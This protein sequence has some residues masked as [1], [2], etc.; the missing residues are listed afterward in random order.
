MCDRLTAGR[1]FA[2]FPRSLEFRGAEG[3][4][5]EEFFFADRLR[6]VDDHLVKISRGPFIHSWVIR[7]YLKGSIVADGRIIFI[8]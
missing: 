2:C 3:A 5:F 1:I 7:H 4:N 6:K 8:V